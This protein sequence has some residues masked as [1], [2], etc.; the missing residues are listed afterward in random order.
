MGFGI[1][2]HVFVHLYTLLHIL[3]TENIIMHC[4]STHECL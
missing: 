2:M 4:A 3:Y 1:F